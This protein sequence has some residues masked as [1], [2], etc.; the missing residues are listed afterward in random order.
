LKNLVA[1]LVSPSSP[2][3]NFGLRL[4]PFDLLLLRCWISFKRVYYI[5][6]CSYGC[7]ARIIERLSPWQGCHCPR[8]NNSFRTLIVALLFGFRRQT[9]PRCFCCSSLKARAVALSPLC[10][11]GAKSI[12]ERRIPVQSQRSERL[13]FPW[14]VPTLMDQTPVAAEAGEAKLE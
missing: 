3:P 11:V 10:G 1:I 5:R 8:R 9:G 6:E 7:M 2:T 4:L 14:Q 13:Q 12:R